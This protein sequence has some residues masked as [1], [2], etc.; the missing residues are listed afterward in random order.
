MVGLDPGVSSFPSRS[1][2]LTGNPISTGDFVGAPGRPP[3]TDHLAVCC[4]HFTNGVATLGLQ[5]CEPPSS[6]GA[7][8]ISFAPLREQ[9]FDFTADCSASRLAELK[10]AFKRRPE[11]R[12]LGS[13]FGPIQRHCRLLGAPQREVVLIQR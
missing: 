3:C 4:E 1:A 11:E 6:R 8:V 7:P 13:P 2:R 12:V 5:L 9:S 10:V